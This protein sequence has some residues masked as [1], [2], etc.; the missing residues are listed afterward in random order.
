MPLPTHV[1]TLAAQT[2]LPPV[3]ITKFTLIKYLPIV[4]S[5]FGLSN[6]LY[7]REKK[8]NLYKNEQ[9]NFIALIQRFFVIISFFLIFT[10]FPLNS[11]GQ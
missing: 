10:P 8:I 7:R 3:Q 6:A 5:S 1:S 4:K 9:A 2:D 11:T